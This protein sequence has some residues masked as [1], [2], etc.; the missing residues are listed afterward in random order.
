MR[1]VDV[2]ELAELIEPARSR[3]TAL[4]Q[5]TG[6][7]VTIVSGRRTLAE[8]IALRQAHCGRDFYS[9]WQKPASQCTPPTARPGTSKHEK[10]LAVDLGGDLALAARR[11]PAAGLRRTVPG[12]NWHFEPDVAAG[13]L[14]LT[15]P[16]IPG[17]DVAG[18]VLGGIGDSLADTLGD[19]VEPLLGGLRRIA[20]VG[21]LITG[22]VALLVAGA[23]RS[24][25]GG[26]R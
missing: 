14:A 10:G 22:G 5:A 12:E 23:V 3:V 1:A 17:V 16:P 7:R 25:Q 18:D 13:V 9:V 20:L 11:A 4:L 24:T 8:Q 6:E 19:V 26:P 15:G 21:V 2:A